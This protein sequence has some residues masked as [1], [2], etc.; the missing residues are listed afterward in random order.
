MRVVYSNTMKFVPRQQVSAFVSASFSAFVPS[1][2]S[3][4]GNDACVEPTILRPVR[5]LLIS[6]SGVDDHSLL[7]LR[8]RRFCCSLR[9]PMMLVGTVS[10]PFVM[11][12]APSLFASLLS[13]LI[14]ACVTSLMTDCCDELLL[15][16]SRYRCLSS[17]ILLL[18]SFGILAQSCSLNLYDA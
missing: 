3:C 13:S 1:L 7:V 14:T 10:L 4:I 6:T 16:R 9:P 11:V 5:I 18:S 8:V 12:V 17:I 15:P 2:G